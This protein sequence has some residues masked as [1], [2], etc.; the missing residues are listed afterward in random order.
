MQG[1][2]LVSKFNKDE[3][4]KLDA[5]IGQLI[6]DLT[7]KSK[8]SEENIKIIGFEGTKNNTERI[9][10]ENM[11]IFLVSRLQEITKDL[12]LNEQLYMDRYK[13]YVGEDEVYTNNNASSGNNK[14][15]LS[16]NS[17]VDPVLQQRG[18]E[19]D[20]LVKSIE[21]L[22]NIFKDLQVL[23]IHQGS[24]L[25]RIDYNIEESLVNTKKAHKE[26][27]EANE[28]MK[29]NCWRN[30]VLMLIIIIF[31]ESLLLLLKYL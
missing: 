19:I 31:V 16:L 11:K 25:D 7:V 20:T 2:R 8:E 5:Q 22:G 12:K 28:N 1:K 27:V 29:S 21:E 24:L 10:K 14:A 4:R 13:E 26:L 3:N 23:V 6:R 30:S 15:M 17:K 9:M 18:Q